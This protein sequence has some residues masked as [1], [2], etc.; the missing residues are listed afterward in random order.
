MTYDF[1][2]NSATD[3][4]DFADSGEWVKNIVNDDDR[5][6]DRYLAIFVD[7][8]FITTDENDWINDENIDVTPLYLPIAIPLLSGHSFTEGPPHNERVSTTLYNIHPIFTPWVRALN[9]KRF[10]HK[11]F[12]AQKSWS[13][14]SPNGYENDILHTEGCLRLQLFR[15]GKLKD[16]FD[17][18]IKLKLLVQQEEHIHRSEH[19]SPSPASAFQ[20]SS[21]STTHANARGC[22]RM[23]ILRQ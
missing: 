19:L 2:V 9:K 20:R 10:I 11:S 18:K 17:S 14:I 12:L 22:P 15:S 4:P 16:E 13:T 1:L 23:K 8:K 6:D 3:L 5:S 21:K 7:K